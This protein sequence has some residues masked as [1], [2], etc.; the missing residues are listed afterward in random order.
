[1]TKQGLA[2]LITITLMMVAVAFS[3]ARRPGVHA[4]MQAKRTPQDTIYAM[5]EAARAGDSRAY[6]AQ[7]TGQMQKSLQQVEAEKGAASF[8]D[9]LRTSIA[10]IRGVAVSEAV[11]TSDRDARIRVE[12]VYQ[13]RNE[14]QLAYLENVSGKWKIARVDGT[15]RLKTLVPYGSPVE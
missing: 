10:D 7:F 12:Y 8:R 5:L 1:M 2:K 9:Y 11:P 6:L 15:E 3:V 14:A 13:D 4:Q